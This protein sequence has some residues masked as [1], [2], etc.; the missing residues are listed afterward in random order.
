MSASD[1]EQQA[2]SN[3]LTGNTVASAPVVHFVKQLWRLQVLVKG[4]E[5]MIEVISQY[6]FSSAADLLVLGS[7]NLCAAGQSLCA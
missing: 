1:A 3:W 6:V 5:G 4:D 2:A 7:H